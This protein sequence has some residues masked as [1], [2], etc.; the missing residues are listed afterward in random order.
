MAKQKEKESKRSAKK[1]H[2]ASSASSSSSSGAA[3][4]DSDSDGNTEVLLST[5]SQS[6]HGA[7]KLGRLV[8]PF[9]AMKGSWTVWVARFEVIANDNEWSEQERLS[10]LLQKLQEA[11]GKYVFEVLSHK[12]RSDYKKLVQELDAQY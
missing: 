2:L 7:P 12:I 9:T 8:P 4:S 6:M 3:L 1:A 11:A 10:V 5:S